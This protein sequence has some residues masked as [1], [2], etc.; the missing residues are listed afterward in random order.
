MRTGLPV[1]LHMRAHACT[2]YTENVSASVR[3]AAA[4]DGLWKLHG[5]RQV[6]AIYSR[7]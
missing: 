6:V 4:A 2:R 1:P 3:N 7:L 5:T